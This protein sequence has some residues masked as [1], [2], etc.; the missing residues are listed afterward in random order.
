VI[1]CIIPLGNGSPLDDI[2]LRYALRAIQKHLTDFR[3]VYIVGECPMFIHNV[4]HIPYPDKSKYKQK[5]IVN[6]ILRACE[7]ESLSDDFIFFNDDHYLLENVSAM[8]FPYY[9]C[10][11]IESEIKR[12]KGEYRTALINTLS[13]LKDVSTWNFDAHFPIRYN[14]EQFKNLMSFVDWNVPYGYV[15]KSLYCNLLNIQPVNVKDGKVHDAISQHDLDEI[16]STRSV[17][18]TSNY[19]LTNIVKR[20]MQELYPE[21]SVYEL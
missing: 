13:A 11:T 3:R 14:K 15:I 10:G 2:E 18:S 21:K 17:W 20:K 1:D 7:E 12:C 9:A 6:K 4:V 5:N 19:A 16:V 8:L